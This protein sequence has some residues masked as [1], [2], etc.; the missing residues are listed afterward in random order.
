MRALAAGHLLLEPQ[1]ATHAAAMFDVLSDPALYEWEG[2]PPPS[3][4][5]LRQRFEQLESRRSGDGR[6]Q[7]LNW[8]VRD[9]QA[10]LVGYVQATIPAAG[11]ASIAYVFH[12]RHWGRGFAFLAVEAMLGEL[13]QSYGVRRAIAVLKRRNVRS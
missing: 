6:Q 13:A 2:E 9:P 4:E 1:S 3:L 5:W 10:G 12:S 11:R 7:W 8:V